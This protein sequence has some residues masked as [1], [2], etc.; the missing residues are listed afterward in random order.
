LIQDRHWDVDAV[1]IV[2]IKIVWQQ[3]S[4]GGNYNFLNINLCLPPS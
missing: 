2:L 3:P 4:M 1:S